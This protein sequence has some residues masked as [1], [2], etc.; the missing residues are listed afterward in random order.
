MKT[1]TSHRPQRRDRLSPAPHATSHAPQRPRTA[2]RPLLAQPDSPPPTQH[3]TPRIPH[4]TPSS[5]IPPSPSSTPAAVRPFAILPSPSSRSTSPPDAT[6]ATHSW[7]EGNGTVAILALGFWTAFEASD[8]KDCPS[9]SLPFAPNVLKRSPMGQTARVKSSPRRRQEIR[10][11]RYRRPRCCPAWRGG[12]F[13]R[14]G[15][16]D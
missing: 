11:R 5:P 16:D 4:S 2:A 15:V 10:D 8:S 3:P 1:S 9:S 6:R 14:L 13:A 12:V 7:R